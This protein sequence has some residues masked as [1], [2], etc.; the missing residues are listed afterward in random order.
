MISP[1][2]KHPHEQEHEASSRSGRH[3]CDC[4][5]RIRRLAPLANAADSAPTTVVITQP[6]SSGY[7]SVQRDGTVTP[8]GTAAA[9]T[10]PTGFDQHGPIVSGSATPSGNGYV[11]VSKEG[12]V[13]ALG[14]AALHGG[15]NTMVDSPSPAK[16]IVL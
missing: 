5:R 2:R 7:W 3:G 1:S 15:S 13:F 4:G 6:N 8:H 16:S 12:G 10:A 9:F 11:V 14:D